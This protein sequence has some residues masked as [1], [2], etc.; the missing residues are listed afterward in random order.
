MTIRQLQFTND[1][2]LENFKGFVEINNTVENFI[3]NNL[4]ADKDRR[5]V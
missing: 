5:I 4:L 1:I 3:R 2:K